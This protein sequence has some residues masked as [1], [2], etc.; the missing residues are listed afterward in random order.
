LCISAG[1]GASRR[2]GGMRE[3]Q[4]D[5][6]SRSRGLSEAGSLTVGAYDK[7]SVQLD[8]N[9]TNVD[10]ELQP[11]PTGGDV[12]LLVIKTGSYAA[13]VTF[14]ADAGATNFV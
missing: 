8:G 14:S 9:A 13:E 10:V 7:V 2:C 1:A 3:R 11:S 12:E 6:R 4:S 5:G